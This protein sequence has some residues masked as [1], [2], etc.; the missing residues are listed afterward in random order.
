MTAYLN[1]KHGPASKKLAAESV[2]ASA[3]PA[4]IPP[5]DPD[6][7]A[8]VAVLVG[9]FESRNQARRAVIAAQ[10]LTE[11]AAAAATATDLSSQPNCQTSPPTVTSSATSAL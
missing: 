7:K 4:V 11:S 2:A 9:A 5:G 6:I 8:A 10:I 3:I 1:L